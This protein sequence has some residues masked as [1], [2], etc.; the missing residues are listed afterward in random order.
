MLRALFSIRKDSGQ[1][2]CFRGGFDLRA[3]FA[4]FKVS[5]SPTLRE[6]FCTQVAVACLMLV[7]KSLT[8]W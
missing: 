2:C 6:G 5:F 8:E 1:A 4:F 3:C 7:F